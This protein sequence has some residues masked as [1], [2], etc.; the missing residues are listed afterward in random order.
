M[1]RQKVSVLIDSEKQEHRIEILIENWHLLEMKK[2]MSLVQELD[3][4]WKY[5]KQWVLDV[6]LKK[7]TLFSSDILTQTWLDTSKT[8]TSTVDTVHCQK[9]IQ[10]LTSYILSLQQFF[11]LQSFILTILTQFISYLQSILSIMSLSWSGQGSNSSSDS[12]HTNDKAS[13]SIS[14]VTSTF[15][16][17]MSLPPTG[18]SGALYF[19]DTNVTDFLKTW[20][21]Q[22]QN[23][24][25][26]EKSM[27]QCLSFYCNDLI[28]EHI[29]SL[30]EFEPHNWEKL[31]EWL[32]KD[33]L[34][35]NLKQWYYLWVYLSQYKQTVSKKNLYIYC[36][37]F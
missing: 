20:K 10:F 37:Q 21:T 14:S 5:W 31:K 24:D 1:N 16:I 29:K 15:I 11:L 26:S 25:L 30:S 22:C 36:I 33:Y 4:K 28:A 18:F 7:K 6:K 27:I 17:Y 13:T 34:Q 2:I 3:M 8:S 35:Q 32:C 9:Q 12:E 23:H 19:N